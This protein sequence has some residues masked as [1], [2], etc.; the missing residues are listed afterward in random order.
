[1][2]SSSK[3]TELPAEVENV[4]GAYL[5]AA[6]LCFSRIFPAILNAAVDLNLFDII[7]KLQNSSSGKNSSFSASEIASELPNQHP[8]LAERLERM[9]NVLASYSLL[10]CSIRTNENGKRERV[11]AL[12]SIGQYFAYDKDGGS[13]GPLST[14]VHRG[15]NS[16]WYDVKD[17]IINPNNN[18]H[19]NKVH[20]SPAYQYLEKNQELNQIFNKAM[21]H[22]GPLEMQR[23]LTLY[24]GFEGVST[25]VDV[26]GGVG[27]ALK[28]II[29]EYPSIKGINF[30]LP[31]VIQDAQ[32][33]SGIEHVEGNMFE[34]VPT[35][36]AILLKL[37]CHNW[38]DEECVKFLRNCHKAL[39]KHGKVIV[40]DYI[41]PEVP[42]SSNISKHACAIDNLMFLI[43]GGMERTENEFQHLC[44]SSGFSKFHIACSDISAMSGVM[45]FYK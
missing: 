5:S 32:P 4:D 16:V 2:S 22:S 45:E 17:A 30:D 8:E 3:Q 42:N 25:L 7:S 33:H 44:M 14:L 39:P 37:V 29:S 1:M 41:I 19:F 15:Y 18:D 12:S 43:H 23:V 40:L 21:A 35:G 13:F 36:D 28:Q 26:G 11:F 6:I 20:G 27:N 9:L 31:Q 34:S 38:A 24:K 10:T